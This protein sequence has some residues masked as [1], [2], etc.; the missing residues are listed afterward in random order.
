M[1]T[2]STNRVFLLADA[3]QT[4][5]AQCFHGRPKKREARTRRQCNKDKNRKTDYQV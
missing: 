2:G 5:H 1:K 3:I 4:E